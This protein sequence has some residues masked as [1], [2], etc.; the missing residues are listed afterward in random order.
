MSL[1]SHCQRLLRILLLTGAT[2]VVWPFYL[3]HSRSIACGPAASKVF[4]SIKWSCFFK[5][6]VAGRYS[7]LLMA[8]G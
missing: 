4:I 7:A 8:A 1:S 6:L 3:F 5:V 2:P